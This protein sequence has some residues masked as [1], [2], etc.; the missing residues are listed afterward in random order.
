LIVEDMRL[1]LCRCGQSHNKPFCDD[2]HRQAAFDD[3]GAVA[4]G[5]AP[6]ETSGELSITASANGPLLVQDAFTL[7]GASG[8]GQYR[9]TNAELCRCGG[10]GHKPFC[11]GTHELIGFRSEETGVEAGP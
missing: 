1:A 10:S 7:R 4:D 8:Q 11:D 3:P 6:A 5:G 2:S 9:A